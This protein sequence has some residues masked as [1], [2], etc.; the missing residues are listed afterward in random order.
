MTV[1]VCE[2]ASE[3]GL[4][5]GLDQ[6]RC[7][8]DL[9]SMMAAGASLVDAGGVSKIYRRVQAFETLGYRVAV[10]RDD[11]V[12]PDAGDENLFEMLGGSVF[13][14]RAGRTLEDEIFASLSA[15]AVQK[16]LERAVDLHGA[17]LV[18]AHLSSASSGT[19][20]LVQCQTAFADTMRPH[21]AAAAQFKS[22]WFKT[23][24]RMEDVARDII[25]PN[26]ATADPA[27]SK[28]LD[29]LFKHL[30]NHGAGD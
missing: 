10:L 16:L 23:V 30:E 20:S 4:L 17:E 13:K 2:G 12:Q 21:I 27:Y 5:R 7:G 8:L 28:I 26:L 6:Y 24:S 14:W 3:V 29:D 1:L 25:G 11:D 9:A 19:L 15:P 22:G 18:E